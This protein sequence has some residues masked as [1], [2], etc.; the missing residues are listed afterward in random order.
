M[1]DRFQPWR[2]RADW[3]WVAAVALF[4]AW[5]LWAAAYYRVP[6]WRR[7]C[8]LTGLA[9]VAAGLLSP[10]EHVALRSMLSFH[11]LQN[12]M[13]ADWAPPLLVLGLTSAM[14]AVAERRAAVRV[15]TRPV[16]AQGYW[17]AVWYGVHLPAV[18]EY[19]LA[20]SWALGIEHL[21]FLTAGLAFWWPL[22]VPGRMR[23]G[24]RLIYVSVAFFLAA[25]VALIIA[26][27]GETI[28][29]YY[30]TTPHLWGLD[31]LED[32]QLGG[33][34]MAVEQSVILFVVAAVALVQL[35]RDEDA[36]VSEA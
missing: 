15:I 26:L 19:G 4:A 23:P 32:Q 31:T 5:Y 22:L 27:A 29:P 7:L 36:V 24:G 34:L 3:P 25:P 35:L 1:N 8:F 12:V 10:I 2:L 13:L 16:V 18:Y 6:V 21:L 14:A 28:Y 30:D 11:L 33:M 9:L 20:R 17:L